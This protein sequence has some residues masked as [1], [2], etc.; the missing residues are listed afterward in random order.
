MY[1]WY[2]PDYNRE[3][4]AYQVRSATR[5]FLNTANGTTV[6]GLVSA[7]Y[8]GPQLSDPPSAEIGDQNGNG[9]TIDIRGAENS[10][11][12]Q[13]I[14]LMTVA[15]VGFLAVV[16][17]ATY[18][19]LRKQPSR[20]E[21]PYVATLENNDQESS[22]EE[23]SG[24]AFPSMLPNSY[25]LESPFSSTAGNSMG[26][27]HESSDGD[28]SVS[29]SEQSSSTGILISEG[30]TT[31]ESSVEFPYNFDNPYVPAAPV[32]GARPRTVSENL[33]RVSRMRL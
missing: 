5:D 31:E 4:I 33:L 6:E 22:V 3:L 18:F 21:V 14:G 17:M 23:T 19:R 8:I 29:V 16:G 1:A 26:T 9:S 27:I 15:G 24:E 20:E 10:L 25:R 13:A 11:S 7:N 28:A 2:M 32:L 30:Y 12:G